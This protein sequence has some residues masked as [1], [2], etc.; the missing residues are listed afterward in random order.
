MKQLAFKNWV[1]V[2]FPEWTGVVLKEAYYSFVVRK[3]VKKQNKGKLF[4]YF[5][6]KEISLGEILRFSWD[7]K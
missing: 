5:G 4:A 2:R 6:G 3:E 7:M 1:Y